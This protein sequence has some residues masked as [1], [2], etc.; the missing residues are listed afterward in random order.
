VILYSHPGVKSFLAENNILAKVELL[1]S[2]NNTLRLRLG[3][4]KTHN[5]AELHEDD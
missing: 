2:S 3:F 5:F 4:A 1:P